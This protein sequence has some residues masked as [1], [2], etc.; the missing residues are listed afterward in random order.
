MVHFGRGLF[1]CSPSKNLAK[2]GETFTLH[3]HQKV[4][5]QNLPVGPRLFG[6]SV[7]TIVSPSDS[8]SNCLQCSI[9]NCRLLRQFFHWKNINC[10]PSCL[11]LLQND[12]ILVEIISFVN[13]THCLT[14]T[15]KL[16]PGGTISPVE[17]RVP[18]AKVFEE[19]ELH[20][21]RRMSSFG[22]EEQIDLHFT[23]FSR[24]NEILQHLRCLFFLAGQESLEQQAIY[25]RSK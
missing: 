1:K 25:D 8:F 19:K 14:R 15:E 18:T 7:E 24:Q 20:E 23:K 21:R 5:P 16:L 2:T 9:F 3:F 13:C 22:E 4:P 17:R 10:L 6:Q 12:S 11:Q